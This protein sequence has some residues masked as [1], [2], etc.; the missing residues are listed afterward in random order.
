MFFYEAIPYWF[1]KFAGLLARRD[2]AYPFYELLQ[3]MICFAVMFVPTVCLGMTLPLASRIATAEVA[4]TGRSVGAV[5]SV[6]TLGTVL[7]AAITGLWLMPALG[8]ARTLA[9]GIALNA[10]LGVVILRRKHFGLRRALKILVPIGAV[11]FVWF[12]GVKF[13]D[14][15]QRAFSLG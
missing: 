1:V 12:A 4:R 8:L 3:A 15:W 7:G 6:S 10:G 9:L 13:N 14:T 2:E 11:V 5:F